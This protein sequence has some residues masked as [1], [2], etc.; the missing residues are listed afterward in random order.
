MACF[1]PLD[2][3][4]SRSGG[5]TFNRRDAYIDQPVKI[6]CGR[7]IGCRIDHSQMWAARCMHEAKLHDEN[8]FITLTYDTDHLPA[9]G[10]LVKEDFQAFI[11]SLRK[12]LG[13]K[14]LRYFHCGEYGENLARPHYH[15]LL[16]GHWFPDA[17]SFGKS[18]SGFPQWRSPT[19]D[20]LW[21][22]GHC[23]IGSVTYQ[24]AG[25]CARYIMKKV[26]GEYADYYYDGRL[27][28]YITMS[29]RP[30]IGAG[31]FAKFSSDAFPSDFIVVEGK[32]HPVP[33]FYDKLL[34]RKQQHE[35]LQIIKNK[36]RRK[37]ANRRN[38]LNSKPARLAV[39]ET[40]LTAKSTLHSR[41]L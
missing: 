26:T 22:K 41:N 3:W 25:Y 18:K 5:L 17:R 36:R 14:K 20:R 19:L 11:K 2:G 38:V 37:A 29:R 13:Q 39:R 23:T 34:K 10:S 27:P 6:R 28:E 40:V 31:W 7:C 1:K 16:F 8:S 12:H 35:E 32:K 30:G 15:A 21:A 4:R 9:G 24:S 33:R